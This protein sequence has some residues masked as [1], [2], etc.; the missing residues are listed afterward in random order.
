MTELTASAVRSATALALTYD[1]S[2][3]E[4]IDAHTAIALRAARLFAK[5]TKKDSPEAF[6]EFAPHI[7]ALLTYT[8]RE[9]P[10][11]VPGGVSTE[12]QSAIIAISQLPNRVPTDELKAIVH[13]VD[14]HA[15]F[16]ASHPADYTPQSWTNFLTDISIEMN[17]GIDLIRA[18]RDLQ[19]E[20]ML[21]GA[22]ERL[23][24]CFGHLWS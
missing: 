5:A 22:C 24:L 20:H 8:G 16:S 14:L 11:A 18:G 4:L 10:P 7:V 23:A 17:L 21:R 6:A 13:L 9:F 2:N 15:R 3:P 19:G 1:I 12:V